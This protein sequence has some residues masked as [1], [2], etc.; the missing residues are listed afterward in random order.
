MFDIKNAKTGKSCCSGWAKYTM[1]SLA[2]NKPVEI[3][4]WVLERYSIADE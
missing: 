1:I 3:P 4:D 2:T